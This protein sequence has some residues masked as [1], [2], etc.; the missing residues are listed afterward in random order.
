MNCQLH[1]TYQANNVLKIIIAA[2]ND[3]AIT[4]R[5]IHPNNFPER[6]FLSSG[7]F[8]IADEP[9]TTATMPAASEPSTT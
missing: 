5:V 8:L 9:V 2:I 4:P 6:A 3:K 1:L 7:S